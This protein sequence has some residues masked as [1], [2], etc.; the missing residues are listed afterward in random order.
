MA[1]ELVVGVDLGTGSARATAIDPHGAVVDTA[2]VAYDTRPQWAPGHAEPQSWRRAVQGALEALGAAVPAA[3]APAALAIGGQSVAVVSSDGAEALTVLHPAA[4][5][6]DPREAHARLWAE[7]APAHPGTEALQTWDWILTTLGAPRQ[8]STWPGTPELPDFGDPVPAG[9]VIGHAHGEWGVAA[10]TPLVAGSADAYMAFW[11]AGIDTPGRGLDVGG[12][13]GGIGVAVPGSDEPPRGYALRSAARGVD[14]LGGAVTA[15]GLAIEWWA[16]TTGQPIE[17]LLDAAAAVEP[18]ARGVLALPYF[19]GERTPRWNRD[20]RA[21]LAGLDPRT[22]PAEVMRA[23]L[24]GCAYGLRHL[25]ESLE[26]VTLDRLVVCGS[27]ARSR[28]WCQIKADVLGVPVDIPEHPE[29]AAYGTALAAGAAVGWW[30]RPGEGDAGAWPVGAC[31]TL[32]P[33]AH[34]AYEAGYAEWIAR[35]DAAQARLES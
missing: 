13:T 11:G 16:R 32:A 2:S 27:P 30:P 19:E 31:T 24:E 25:V 5:G 28:L 29:L 6:A 23:L 22:T 33:Q 8:Q 18:G 3:R 1:S 21:E 14:I 10:G 12:R 35:G 20:L 17:S 34:A 4:G 15:H 9:T 7:L 26:G